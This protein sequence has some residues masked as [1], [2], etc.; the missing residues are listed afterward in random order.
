MTL[1]TGISSVLRGHYGYYGVPTNFAAL[2]SV[3]N[4]VRAYWHEQLQRRSQRARWSQPK[5]KQFDK[6][7][8]LPLPRIVHPW[9]SL[10]C[11][12]P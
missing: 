11:A 1:Q 2:A 9:P 6:R 5:R 10:R 3:R 7:Y 4:Q 8:P 12:L